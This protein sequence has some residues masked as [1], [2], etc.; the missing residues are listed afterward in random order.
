MSL[1]NS[2]DRWGGI[3]QLLHWTIAVLILTIGAVGLLMG[4]LPRSP[5]WFWVYTAHKSLG[6]TVLALVIVRIAWR[7]Y[8]GAP[9]PV[10]GT[11]RWQAKLASLTHA[12]IY[13]LILAMPL[14]GWLYDSASGL[15]PLR[16]F[17]L[18]E[19][20]KISPPNEAIAG[21]MH[22]THELLFWVLLALVA[23]HAAAALYHHFFQR[24][25]TLSRMLP[26]GWLAAG[27]PSPSPG[28]DSP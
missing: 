27:T 24:D 2:T 20:P 18:A 10:P 17:G 26:R 14:S 28:K 8:A 7:L 3:S 15:R 5:K 9:Q 1:K 25:A 4:E 23:G 12:A 16:W 11:P 19:V 21:A 13:L 6:L 22:E